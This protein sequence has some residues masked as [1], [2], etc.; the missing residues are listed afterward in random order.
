VGHFTR[1]LFVTVSAKAFRV[2]GVYLRIPR[3]S[4]PEKANGNLTDYA[5][6]GQRPS[7]LI[8]CRSGVCCFWGS[9]DVP[10]ALTFLNG[11]I[12]GTFNFFRASARGL[13]AGF[14]ALDFSVGTSDRQTGWGRLPML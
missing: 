1:K 14:W 4:E 11:F 6:S 12:V 10:F 7:R 9:A 3:L 2:V 5:I 8:Q 13:R